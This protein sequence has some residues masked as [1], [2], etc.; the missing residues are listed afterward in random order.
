VLEVF[1]LFASAFPA[2]AV[3]TKAAAV[4]KA[5]YLILAINCRLNNCCILNSGPKAVLFFGVDGVQRSLA[6]IIRKPVAAS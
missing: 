1:A 3:K 4:V 2:H 5:K 6:D